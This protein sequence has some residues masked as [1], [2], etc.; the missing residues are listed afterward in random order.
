MKITHS[1]WQ[2]TFS[3]RPTILL[4]GVEVTEVLEADDHEGTVKKYLTTETGTPIYAGGQYLTEVLTGVVE[5]IGELR[6]DR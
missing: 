1:N 5:I 6:T 2:D 3:T 4:D